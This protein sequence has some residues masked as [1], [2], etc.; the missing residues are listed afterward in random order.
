MYSKL[1]K[2][3]SNAIVHFD[4]AKQFF[5]KEF[6]QLFGKS[7]KNKMSKKTV[8]NNNLNESYNF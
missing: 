2:D 7:S 5:P 1:K 6:K 3:Q 8:K 4:E